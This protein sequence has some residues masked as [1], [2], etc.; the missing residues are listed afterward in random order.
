MFHNIA[1]ENFEDTGF[2]RSVSI[3][4][5]KFKLCVLYALMEFKVVRFNELQRYIGN[6]SVKTLSSVL[7]QLQADGLIE[8]K[9][10]H[11]LPLKVEYSLT[12]HGKTLIPI[13]DSLCEWGDSNKKLNIEKFTVTV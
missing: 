7:K 6:I 12:A 10:Y 4:S 13:L 11:E 8:R 9:D 5:G 1:E 2:C 3:I